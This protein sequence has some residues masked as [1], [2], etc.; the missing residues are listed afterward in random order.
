LSVVPETGETAVVVPYS[1]NLFRLIVAVPLMLLGAAGIIAVS[2]IV[3]VV[4][5][6]DGNS[7]VVVLFSLV[8]VGYLLATLSQLRNHKITCGYVALSASGVYHRSWA[9][10]S[11]APWKD[12]VAVWPFGGD[13]QVVRVQVVANSDGWSRRTS[14]FW[15]Q[16]ES[17][18]GLNLTVRGMYLSVDP[19]LLY[20]A[21]QFYFNEPGARRELASDMGVQR[22]RRVDIPVPSHR[23]RGGAR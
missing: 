21:L 1:T 10:T 13:G 18:S 9:L 15:K 20:H 5:S 23:L 22:L 7:V 6:R 2:S 12:I 17:K 3:D 14:R 16:S 4:M 19:A 8:V 11:Y